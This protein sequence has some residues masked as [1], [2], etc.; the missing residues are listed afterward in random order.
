MRTNIHALSESQ[1]HDPSM[2]AVWTHTS[3]HVATVIRFVPTTTI[4][5]LVMDVKKANMLLVKISSV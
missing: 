3:D 4:N 1:T 5:Q 2:Q